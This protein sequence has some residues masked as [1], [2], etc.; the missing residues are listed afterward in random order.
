MNFWVEHNHCQG[1][2][3]IIDLPDVDPD[4]GT[5]ISKTTYRGCERQTEVT[6]YTIFGGGHTW[7]TRQRKKGLLR[8]LLFDP[9]VGRQSRD[10]DA[11]ELIWDFF[12]THP[13][14]KGD[15]Q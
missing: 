3:Q 1:S 15:H 7:P 6:Q 12:S 9:L 13:K 5:R 14:P 4:D 10:I 11:C 2:A 8:K